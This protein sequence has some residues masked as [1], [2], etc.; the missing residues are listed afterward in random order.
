MKT[1][2]SIEQSANARK[3]QMKKSCENLTAM[4]D[5]LDKVDD[6]SALSEIRKELSSMVQ[7]FHEYN[8]YRNVLKTE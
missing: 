1:L 7:A 6:S 2:N 8:A 5:L 4:M 3:A